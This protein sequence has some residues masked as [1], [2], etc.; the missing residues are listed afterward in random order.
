MDSLNIF[1]RMKDVRIVGFGQS[2]LDDYTKDAAA[3][4][5][6]IILPNATPEKGSFYR[7]DHFP[8]AKQGV[9]AL[10]ARSGIQHREKGEEWGRNQR[11]AYSKAHYHK[12]SDEFDPNWDL[13]GAIED[14][15]LYF[16][17]GY[18]LS[19]ES[20]FPN[21][22]EGSEFKAKRDAD[23]KGTLDSTP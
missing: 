16:K 14:L 6:R 13:S 18:R 5:D 21:W 9:P 20:T 12:P 8:F 4:Q 17:I 1:G 11:E 22:K 3:E 23:M 19:M 7:S 2:E 10:S 15:R